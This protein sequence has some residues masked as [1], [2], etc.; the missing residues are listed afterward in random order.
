MEEPELDF[1]DATKSAKAIAEDLV[2]ALMRGLLDS[3]AADRKIREAVREQ[4]D[5]EDIDNGVELMFDLVANE[6]DSAM[7]HIRGLCEVD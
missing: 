6:L 3:E 2:D 7:G 4:L 1:D 5:T